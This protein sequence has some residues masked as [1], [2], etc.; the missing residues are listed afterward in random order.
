[1]ADRTDPEGRGFWS[2]IP[3]WLTAIGSFLAA[4]TGLLAFLNHIGLIGAPTPPSIP[5]ITQ[6]PPPPTTQSPAARPTDASTKERTARAEKKL[7]DADGNKVAGNASKTPVSKASEAQM[8]KAP[9]ES[10]IPKPSEAQ[11]QKAPIESPIPRSEA[12]KPLAERQAPAL[13]NRLNQHFAPSQSFPA[14]RVSLVR[15]DAGP[16]PRITVY[17]SYTNQTGGDLQLGLC[18]P[19]SR[20]TTRLTDDTA[21][22]YVFVSGSGV[23]DV[24][25]GASFPLIVPAGATTHASM[26]FEPT[27]QVR[28]QPATFSL[29]SQHVIV[30]RAQGALQVQS[31]H[32]VSLTGQLRR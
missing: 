1:M 10:P 2:T 16:G 4:V 27:T 29:V 9:T 26:V 31:T 25:T 5:P 18:Y 7:D 32:T 24:C 15:L 14:F 12:E 22:D 3:G 21:Y 23:G 13:T 20:N 11:M 17:L 19:R 6:A 30:E 8:Q 28:Q